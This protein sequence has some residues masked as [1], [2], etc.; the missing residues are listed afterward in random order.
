MCFGQSTKEFKQCRPV[1]SR[2]YLHGDVARKIYK[3]ERSLVSHH[4]RSFAQCG[5]ACDEKPFMP[6][7]GAIAS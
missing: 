5:F 4:R 6:W 2:W 7:A 3:R 1:Y